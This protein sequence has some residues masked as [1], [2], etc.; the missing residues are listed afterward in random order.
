MP[1]STTQK[2]KIEDPP[3]PTRE[4]L[5]PII[6]RAILDTNRIDGRGASNLLVGI[7]HRVTTRLNHITTL[8]YWDGTVTNIE[9]LLCGKENA[10]DHLHNI[11]YLKALI[12]MIPFC[13]AHVE[14]DYLLNIG[15][16]EQLAE[17]KDDFVTV[18]YI[19]RSPAECPLDFSQS[20]G[21]EVME[22]VIAEMATDEYSDP[23]E[24]DW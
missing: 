10:K 17:Y 18:C 5:A 22:N 2:T 13:A 7:I 16:H 20:K 6:A 3:L 4:E 1:D 12:Q 8:F 9:G 11:L 14:G 21:Y 19:F 15:T 23:I 24:G